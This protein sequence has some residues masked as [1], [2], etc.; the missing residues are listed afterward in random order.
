LKKVKKVIKNNSKQI[1]DEVF[2]FAD[3]YQQDPMALSASL[4][5]VAK[6]IYLDILGPEQTSDMFYAFAQDL[7]QHKYKKATIH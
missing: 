7:E 2:S 5:V 3:Q 4:L 1:L 6:T